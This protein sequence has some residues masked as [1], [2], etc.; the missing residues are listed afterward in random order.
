MVFAEGTL[1]AAPVRV[2]RP[3]LADPLTG[4][5]MLKTVSHVI[6]QNYCGF[7]GCSTPMRPI[8]VHAP[9]FGWGKGYGTVRDRDSLLDDV[10][11]GSLILGF[12]KCWAPGRLSRARRPGYVRSS[13]RFAA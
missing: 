9:G 3:C 11:L 5:N 6:V 13:E 1:V 7:G 4:G 8:P 12:G 10:V 2:F